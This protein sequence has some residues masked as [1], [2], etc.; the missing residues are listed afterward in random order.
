MFS[1]A[2]KIYGWASAKANTALAPLWLGCVF[3]LEMIFFLPMDAILVLFCLEN[4]AR[5]YLYA[6][7]ATAASLVSALVGYFL[8]LLAWD[9]VGPYVIGHLVSA[10]FFQN[11]V[12]HYTQYQNIAVFLGSFLPLPFKAITL[13]AG[14]CELAVAPF[15]AMIVCARCARFFLIAK[16]VERWGVQIKA[17]IDRHFKSLVVAISAK[18]AIVFGFFWALGQ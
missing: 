4:P 10:G 6:A 17:F 5:R 13:S 1:P 8:G 16:A 14:V 11:L 7:I 15:L 2:K 3:L 18:I 12:N 9:I